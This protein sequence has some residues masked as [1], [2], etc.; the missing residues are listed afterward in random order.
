MSELTSAYKN[1]MYD[2][3]QIMFLICWQYGRY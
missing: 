1:F 2:T 3:F